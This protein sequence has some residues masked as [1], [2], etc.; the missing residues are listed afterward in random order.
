MFELAHTYGHI[1]LW[2]KYVV[3]ISLGQEYLQ[4]HI[5]IGKIVIRLNVLVNNIFKYD[6][7]V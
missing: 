6:Y 2:G 1:Y 4:V 5:L 7:K 3:T